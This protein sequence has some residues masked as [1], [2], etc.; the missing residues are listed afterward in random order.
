MKQRL[1][2]FLFYKLT[3]KLNRNTFKFKLFANLKIF[4]VLG[5]I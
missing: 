3:V 5:D 4:L 1:S 2:N